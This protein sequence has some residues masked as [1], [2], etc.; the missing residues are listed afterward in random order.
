[1]SIKKYHNMSNFDDYDETNYSEENACCYS[2]CG[3][4]MPVRKNDRLFNTKT[5]SETTKHILKLYY[6]FH[7]RF[8]NLFIDEHA[9]ESY[10]GNKTVGDNGVFEMKDYDTRYDLTKLSYTFP[11]DHRQVI[12]RKHG[13]IIMNPFNAEIHKRLVVGCGHYP[14][15]NDMDDPFWQ[16]YSN[17]H[18]HHG[19]YTIDPD[20]CKNADTVGMFGEQKFQNLPDGAF[21]EI[22]TE[23][24]RL[25]PT[26]FFMRETNRLLKEGGSFYSDGYLLF[27]K[28]NGKLSFENI[29]SCMGIFLGIPDIYEWNTLEK[30]EDSRVKV[31]THKKL[32]MCH[33]VKYNKKPDVPRLG[34]DE[35]ELDTYFLTVDIS[36]FKIV[37]KD[38]GMYNHI[39]GNTC[40]YITLKNERKKIVSFQYNPKYDGFFP[41]CENLLCGHTISIEHHYKFMCGIQM[42]FTAENG[43]MSYL[44]FQKIPPKDYCGCY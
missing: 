28:K 18:A 7:C 30:L 29:S 10:F 41:T 26:P 5:F 23:G 35:D 37:V 20:L 12:F 44:T 6:Q 24:V 15:E 32:P 36:R 2:H 11:D 22:I 34:L 33:H 43:R 17:Q 31:G 3:C 16:D 27:T 39:I 13:Y 9:S 19:C 25:I 8:P 1:M 4:S 38:V 40:Y 21:T 14:I 42:V